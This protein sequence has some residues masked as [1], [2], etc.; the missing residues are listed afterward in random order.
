MKKQDRWFDL[1]VN[2]MSDSQMRRYSADRHIRRDSARMGVPTFLLLL[3]QWYQRN[4]ELRSKCGESALKDSFDEL[5]ELIDDSIQ[6]WD[7]DP[8][9][10]KILR[11]Y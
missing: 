5:G 2:E 9:V 7:K 1:S 3:A 4:R 8:I 10:R 11:A 6:N